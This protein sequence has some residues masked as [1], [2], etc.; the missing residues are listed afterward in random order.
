MKD[1]MIYYLPV[2]VIICACSASP[3]QKEEVRYHPQSPRITTT[4]PLEIGITSKQLANEYHSNDVTEIEFKTN[5]PQISELATAELTD[6]YN[7]TLEK[8]MI[9]EVILITWSDKEFPSQ[10]R[11]KLTSR[12]VRLTDKRNKELKKALLKL[13]D[14]LVIEEVNM[15]YR[16]GFWEKFLATRSFRIKTSLDLFDIATTSPQDIAPQWS[17]HSIVIFIPDV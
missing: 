4:Q 6:L 17:S 13:D 15:A 11:S 10:R 8:N 3:P 7:R 2:L 5:S 1:L 16:S 14:D 9:K 12:Q